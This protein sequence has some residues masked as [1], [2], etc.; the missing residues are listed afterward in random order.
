MDRKGRTKIIKQALKSIGAW[1]KSRV[2]DP[3]PELNELHSKSRG[4]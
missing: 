4:Q 3:N 1:I 2:I